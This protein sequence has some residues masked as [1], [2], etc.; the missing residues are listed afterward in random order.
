MNNVAMDTGTEVTQA[1][2]HMDFHPPKLM[3]LDH[4]SCEK[5]S[6]LSLLECM[7]P[8][9]RG[10]RSLRAMPAPD[11][12][13]ADPRERLSRAGPGTPRS[14]ALS[15]ARSAAPAP[16]RAALPGLPG[17]GA[18]PS[19]S[20]RLG[21]A[22]AS[23]AG[24]A[25]DH[26]SQGRGEAPPKAPPSPGRASAPRPP[27]P[28]GFVAAGIPERKRPQLLNAPRDPPATLVFLAPVA[29]CSGVLEALDPKGGKVLPNRKPDTDSAELEV[30]TPPGHGRSSRLG[31][32]GQ[33]RGL[34]CWLR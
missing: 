29:L 8:R 26:G 21:R 7:L 20:G 19:R 16:A 23:V 32:S 34:L 9:E 31:I 12:G 17:V 18:P 10:S 6:V 13:S 30:K 22:Q 33:G 3:T 27:A 5:G 11:A 2:S 28:L 15:A 1:L 24:L 4:F 25:G 14:P